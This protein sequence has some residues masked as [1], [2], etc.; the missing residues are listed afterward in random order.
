MMNVIL[1]GC[2]GSGKGT[3]AKM[4][5]KEKGLRHISTGDMFRG[6]I[7]K[8]TPLGEQAA[9][10]INAGA[11]VPD[12]VVMAVVK[13]RLSK[14]ADGILLDGFPRT[15]VQ[16][17]GLDESFKAAGRKIDAVVYIALDEAEVVRRISSRR[18]CAVCGQMF[19]AEGGEK[20]G[21]GGRLVTRADDMPETVKKRLAVYREETSPLVDY[22]SGNGR[23][24]EVNGAATP[25]AVSQDI[26]K[27]LAGAQ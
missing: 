17:K 19:G 22:Y 10:Y 24:F 16:G 7:A 27:A 20:C 26:L 21:C 18:T 1:L 3:Q 2:P 4:L 15:L 23:F 6:E 12:E 8:G 5:V 11:L 14:E 13:E 9:G 25:Q